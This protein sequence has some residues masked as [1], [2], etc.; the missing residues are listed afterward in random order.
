[1]GGIGSKHPGYEV[2]EDLDGAWRCVGSRLGARFGTAG[3]S[4]E[5]RPIP[6][7]DF[8]PRSGPSILLTGLVHG[9][10]LVGGLAL[11]RLVEDLARAVP[12]AR[13]TVLPV[14]NPDAVAEN[15]SKL[16]A[17]RTAGR[18]S[19]RNG[20]DLNRNFA[21][22]GPVP[23]HPFGGSSRPGGFYYI[24]PRP[25]S[26]PETR[27]VAEVASRVRPQ[28]ALG[29][30][31]FGEMLLYPWAYTRAP[32]PRTEPYRALGRVFQS[33][34]GKAAYDLRPAH[35]LYP[36]VGDLDDWLDSELGTMAFTVEV[37]RPC[38]RLL[39]P[40]RLLDPFHWMNPR[41][42]GPSIGRSVVGSRALIE[43]FVAASVNRQAMSGERAPAPSDRPRLAAR[44]RLTPTQT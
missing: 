4:V 17:G 15:V 5:G 8:G 36:T 7:L 41:T 31:S 40:R 32:H 12:P 25:F 30:H 23:R 29:Y 28:L 38:R 14:V 34:Q 19:N 44:S 3:H 9:I 10:E 2:L 22:L 16:A 1:M 20:V 18:R 35:A 39:H 43:R 21:R 11:L 42:P 27:T 13:F 6:R 37:G 26:E 33:A 24:G